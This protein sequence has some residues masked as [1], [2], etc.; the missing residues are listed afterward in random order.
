MGAVAAD[1]PERHAH[2]W[3]EP[4]TQSLSQHRSR[5]HRLDHVAGFGTDC[6]R[7]HWRARAGDR[8]DRADP[9]RRLS[10]SL[11]GVNTLPPKRRW[12]RMTAESRIGPPF[13]GLSFT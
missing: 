6:C 13:G 3:S 7:S 5:T 4:Y 9:L 8:Y 11:T 1:D 12:P 10:C 2:S